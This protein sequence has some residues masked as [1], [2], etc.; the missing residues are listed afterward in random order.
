[1]FPSVD[2]LGD[3]DLFLFF[4]FQLLLFL[5][6]FLYSRFLLVTHFIHISV[7]M[8]IPIYWET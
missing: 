7:Y 2:L 3:L 4:F 1:M 6:I 8:S 5:F